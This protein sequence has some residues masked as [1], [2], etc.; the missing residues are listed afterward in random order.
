MAKTPNALPAD[1]NAQIDRE[2]AIAKAHWGETFDLNWLEK[3][4]AATRSMTP[5]S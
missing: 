2:L 5:I 1:N 3:A 4:A